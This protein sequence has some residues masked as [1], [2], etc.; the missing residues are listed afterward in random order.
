M[1]G[2][3]TG[4]F[5]TGAPAGII[6][7]ASL[8]AIGAFIF[9]GRERRLFLQFAAA[10]V[11]SFIVVLCQLAFTDSRQFLPAIVVAAGLGAL[12]A[13]LRVE[14][15]AT[16]LIA[17]TGAQAVF[18]SVH[19]PADAWAVAWPEQIAER[20]T[21]AYLGALGPFAVTSALF[22]AWAVLERSDRL[23]VR[24]RRVAVH[25]AAIIVGTAVVTTVLWLAEAAEI[26]RFQVTGLHAMSWPVAVAVT[27][28]FLAWLRPA[29]TR[30]TTA[31]G[32]AV[33]RHV[34][35][36]LFG[37]TALPV[38]T[39]ALF[40]LFGDGW[41][42]LGAFYSGFASGPVPTLLSKWVFSV[43]ILPLLLARAVD[44]R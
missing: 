39:V 25:L 27:I 1:G 40:T 35:L 28:P 7:G 20:V 6:A 42:T 16:A 12:L 11:A 9:A 8:G 14:D 24:A 10:A 23:A 17:F 37:V 29:N 4:S 13:Q 33:A 21:V 36:M 30:R 43:G 31:P 3:I 18:Q 5:A 44:T 34:A 32:A 15:V 22:I 19:V 26:T 2:A 38:S 41:G